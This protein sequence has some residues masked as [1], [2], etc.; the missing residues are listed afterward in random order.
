MTW[1]TIYFN[2]NYKLYLIFK[3]KLLLSTFIVKSYYI[4]YIPVPFIINTQIAAK[5]V[6]QAIINNNNNNL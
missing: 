1:S 2:Y 4:R 5:K 6:I 3:C